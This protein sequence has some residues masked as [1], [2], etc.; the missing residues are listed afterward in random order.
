MPARR[1]LIT[2][3]TEPKTG[4]ATEFVNSKPY[5]QSVGHVT[6][7]AVLAANEY[8]RRDNYSPEVIGH[9][10]DKHFHSRHQ[11]I[12]S[13]P[14]TLYTPMSSPSPPT[15]SNGCHTSSSSSS[16]S[17][18]PPSTPPNLHQNTI[19]PSAKWLVQKFGGTTIGKFPVKIAS[20]VVSYVLL[21]NEPI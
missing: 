19:D 18:S 7:E 5:G 20:E 4:Q 9:M 13:Q 3:C 14:L 1:L 10:S 8:T 17:S 2:R 15:T 11:S 6:V 12:L 21:P 16:S